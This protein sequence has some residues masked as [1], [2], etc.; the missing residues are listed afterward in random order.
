MLSDLS[1][2]AESLVPAN[3][4]KLFALLETNGEALARST[5]KP[6]PMSLSAT[7]YG[8][9]NLIDG[10]LL[11]AATSQ[12]PFVQEHSV[13]QEPLYASG[14]Q[15]S[16][17]G[18][19]CA[20]EC[21]DPKRLFS[22][23]SI[24]G[25]CLT[26][27][28][29]AILAE[30]GTVIREIS[31]DDS[32]TP[33]RISGVPENINASQIF[34]DVV[35]CAVSSCQDDGRT[36][37]MA[38]CTPGLVD[39]EK[40]LGG[41]FS[42]GLEKL[43]V[44]HDGLSHYCGKLTMDF[45][46]DIAGPGA[47]ANILM[48]IQ[49]LLSQM[50]QASVSFTSFVIITAISSWARLILLLVKQG[51]WKKAQL[52][53]RRLTACRIHGALVSA[54]MEFQEAQTFFTL[55]IQIATV[56][57][58]EPSFTCGLSCS[59]Q[60]SIQSLSETIM[61]GQLIRALAV[62]SM[63]PVLLTQSVL[64]RAGMSWWYTLILALIVCIFSEVI[65]WQTVT[66][67]PFHILLSRLRNLVPVE[68]C[69]GNPALTAY[70]LTPLYN[71]QLVEMP[72][73]I[74][75]YITALVL[76]LDQSAHQLW[77][78]LS[79]FVERTRSGQLLTYMGKHFFRASWWG[80]Q[81]TLAIGTV[82]HFVTLWSISSGLGASSKDWTYGQVVS[83]M[84][85]A[86]ILGKYIYYNIFGVKGGVEAR[87][88]R[89]YKALVGSLPST[90]LAQPQHPRNHHLG[91]SMPP[92]GFQL[93]IRV[94]M[95]PTHR[96]CAT[97]H[98]ETD[99]M[100][101]KPDLSHLP[102]L[103]YDSL[104]TATSIRIL[105]LLEP[106][107]PNNN[108]IRCSIR[109]IDLDADPHLRPEYVA[110]SYTWGNPITIQESIP[111]SLKGGDFAT[112]PFYCSIT[113]PNGE[114][115]GWCDMAKWNYFMKYSTCMVPGEVVDWN[116]GG[117]WWIEVDGCGVQVQ[118]NLFQFLQTVQQAR[119]T[120]SSSPHSWE[121]PKLE[122]IWHNVCYPIWI[123][124]VCINQRDV[125][126][127]GSQV[128]LMMR[129]FQS[130]KHVLAWA[131]KSDR[132][133][134]WGIQAI[135]QLRLWFRRAW[136]AQEATFAQHTS[137]MTSGAQFHMTMILV[138]LEVLDRYGLEDDFLQLGHSLVIPRQLAI[139]PRDAFNF[140]RGFQYLRER[141][142]LPGTGTITVTG[143]T[144]HALGNFH[145]QLR[146]R[147][148]LLSVIS[149]FRNLDATDPRDKVFAFLNMADENTG[150]VPNYHKSV[151]DVFRESAEAIIKSENNLSILSHIEDPSDSKVEG[152]PGWVPDFSA[153]L[154]TKPFDNG[155]DEC[156]FRALSSSPK[157]EKANTQIVPNA[158][159]GLSVLG[160][161]ID[162]VQS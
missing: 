88:A 102:R 150:I 91:L 118:D 9:Q 44:I 115:I 162:A 126:E 71:L 33:L 42:A 153:K 7:R 127:R 24:L 100:S 60:D 17:Q 90:G 39:L 23:L 31:L 80:L 105:T 85:W 148:R 8:S 140:L 157:D 161:C 66:Q 22:S 27:A 147:I 134:E 47:G 144:E 72:M 68:E 107:P 155:R 83:A 57:T 2:R 16:L 123:D 93:Q 101:N 156:R 92:G 132:L 130:A 112:M 114:E 109:T 94:V 138:A 145:N 21:S 36:S 99:T 3:V 73:L 13:W 46:P 151:Q 159:G 128:S 70:C 136:I 65:R 78:P 116:K 152:I 106:K 14:C 37:D 1:P 124:A 160:F 59:Q 55:A 40:H 95:P 131:G 45:E 32:P 34:Q 86:P 62:N 51:D 6:S 58:F 143:R 110:L 48:S 121:K 15:G 122:P 76:L 77:P 38:A 89:E 75:G 154:E 82:L 117:L 11:P 133:S 149:V 50:I 108:I 4:D 84:L 28:T 79:P 19:L 111:D 67:A 97:N 61:N 141:M 81:L 49:V 119:Q 18:E 139:D 98:S 63:L 35:R 103:V 10:A 125:D 69:G 41:S 74:V 56:A 52:R 120:G 137:V 30:N 129:V 87:L 54:A 64:H 96:C 142:D 158:N 12:R 43:D 53:H 5:W 25:N 29:A 104:P 26:F 135:S 113:G 146:G 20:G